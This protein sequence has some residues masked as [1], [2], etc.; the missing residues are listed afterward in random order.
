MNKKVF[1][2]IAAVTVGTIAASGLVMNPTAAFA[3]EGQEQAAP[4]KSCA[5]AKAAESDKEHKGDSESAGEKKAESDGEM[6]C[7]PN[8]CSGK[9]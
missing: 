9:K 8:A 1:S 5:G 7:S 4:A 3:G 6:S 2:T